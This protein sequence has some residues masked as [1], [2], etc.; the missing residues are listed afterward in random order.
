MTTH[1]NPAATKKV[2]VEV[3]PI[4]F[5]ARRLSHALDVSRTTLYRMVRRGEIPAPLR[6][7]R[8]CVGWR[9][10][11]IDQ[12]LAEREQAAQVGR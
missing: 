1:G 10:E 7:S 6:I 9:A 8:G 4:I 2:E 12:L 5:R 3:E 11:T